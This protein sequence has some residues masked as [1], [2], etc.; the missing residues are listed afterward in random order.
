MTRK[1]LKWV[2]SSYEDMC[3]FP[4]EVRRSLGYALH[5]AQIGEKHTHAKVFSGMG[6]AKVW[7]I[8]ENAKSGTYRV[9]YTVEYKEFIFVLHA[10]QKKSSSGIATP[11]KE[12][13]LIKDRLEEALE[14]NKELNEKGENEKNKKNQTQN[15]K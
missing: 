10:F 12:L 14:F 9:V 8:K 4:T 11:K 7:E 1:E 13:D 3:E 15:K 2:G 6:N 5:L